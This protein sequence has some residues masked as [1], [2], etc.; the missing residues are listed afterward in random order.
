[1]FHNVT[2]SIQALEEH[3][4]TILLDIVGKVRLP[5]LHMCKQIVFPAHLSFSFPHFT[6]AFRV[7]PR[8]RPIWA[9][10]NDVECPIPLSMQSIEGLDVIHPLLELPFFEAWKDRYCLPTIVF[11][12]GSHGAPL[13]CHLLFC[14]AFPAQTDTALG[15]VMPV[16]STKSPQLVRAGA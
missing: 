12:N 14:K 8:H 10:R 4:P 16:S 5:S 6:E 9:G 13:F 11:P 7:S 3:W 2:L 15:P 1:M